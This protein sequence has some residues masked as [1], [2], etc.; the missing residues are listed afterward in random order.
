M[1]RRLLA[2]MTVM[3]FGLTAFTISVGD[4]DAEPKT[5]NTSDYY[6]SHGAIMWDPDY[7]SSTSNRL[8]FNSGSE[9]HKT[10]MKYIDDSETIVTKDDRE[11]L[12]GE[13]H[14]YLMT[15]YQTTDV[16][17]FVKSGGNVSVEGEIVKEP[18]NN[19]F[20]VKAG[21][22]FSIRA[23]SVKNMYGEACT[24]S[25]NGT[26]IAGTYT[27]V[28]NISKEIKISFTDDNPVWMKHD[29]Q[30]MFY[31]VDYEATG[32]SEPNGSAT[33]FIAICAVMAVIGL[34]LLV[35]AS[36]KPKWSK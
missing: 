27:E 15:T 20:F 18:F 21:D 34:G 28:A 7:E 35:I 16:Y 26:D 12:S 1:D 32:Y 24:A 33:S 30:S 29:Y 36:I 22:T 8:F 10:M 5:E 25:I 23:Y 13:V 9:N 3:M 14:I 31:V 11:N 4:T 2:V 19:A 17:V 6:I